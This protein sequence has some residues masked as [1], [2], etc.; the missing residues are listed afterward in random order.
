MIFFPC[1]FFLLF[2][3]M[4]CRQSLH[5]QTPKSKIQN[6]T[7]KSIRNIDKTSDS[8]HLVVEGI[9]ILNPR[10]HDFANAPWHH[11]DIDKTSDSRHLVVEGIKIPN[12]R[13][14]DFANA[15]WHHRDI[16]KTSDSRH[17]VVEGI[18]IPNPRSH[19]FANAPWH[20]RDIDKTSDS[21]HLVVEGIKIPNPRSTKSKLQ[22]PGF[23]IQ[24]PR[25]AKIQ[26]PKSKFHK[27]KTQY[28]QAV[29]RQE[30]GNSKK[31]IHMVALP[32]A[33]G[34]LPR[35]RYLH[36]PA[37]TSNSLERQLIHQNLQGPLRFANTIRT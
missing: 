21:R 14:H 26:H 17:L 6:Q 35:K 20:H 28:S 24:N 3:L 23:N 33:L 10:S 13:S 22:N 16:D 4:S 11:R 29:K 9:K 8:T 25:R 37:N 5:I 1:C 30:K 7:S 18:K 19:D 15:P 36:G 34:K 27:S 2:C 32:T 12:P 31:R